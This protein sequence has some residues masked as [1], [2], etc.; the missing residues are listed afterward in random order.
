MAAKVAACQQAAFC[1][2]LATVQLVRSPTWNMKLSLGLSRN[3]WCMNEVF[4]G[5]LERGGH[6][7]PPPAEGVRTLPYVT[8]PY[9]PRLREG[10]VPPPYGTGPYQPPLREGSVPRPTGKVR[11]TQKNRHLKILMTTKI[12]QKLI[13][14]RCNDSGTNKI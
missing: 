10:S 5:P 7:H 14:T 4:L 1:S 3:T 8:G 9:Q 12:P 11:T 13:H 6:H 2:H